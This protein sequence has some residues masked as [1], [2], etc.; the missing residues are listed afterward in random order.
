M[1]DTAR[2]PPSVVL[3]V[4]SR[5]DT[6]F[7]VGE[8]ATVPST[9]LIAVSWVICEVWL[10]AVASPPPEPKDVMGTPLPS[11]ISTLTGLPIVGL[12]VPCTRGDPLVVV[13]AYSGAA[14]VVASSAAPNMKR[15][16]GLTPTRKGQYP[17]Q[18]GDAQLRG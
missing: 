11:V 14:A 2:V 3:I 17:R 13:C 18:R 1:P 7:A 5:S 8:T 16:I 15:F 9:V 12:P 6:V 10:A 4:L